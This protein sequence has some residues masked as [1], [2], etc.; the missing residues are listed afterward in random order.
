MATVTGSTLVR[1]L[2]DLT[3]ISTTGNITVGGTVDGRDVAAD[4]A[5]LDS[6][7]ASNTIDISSA[8]ELSSDIEFSDND[9]Y[10]LS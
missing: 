8:E 7:T 2:T 4:G 3:S 6:A 9:N 10:L 1:D 5:T